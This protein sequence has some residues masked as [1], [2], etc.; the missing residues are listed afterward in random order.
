MSYDGGIIAHA[1]KVRKR[2]K[3]LFQTFTI[4]VAR[5]IRFGSDLTG[6]PG[7]PV[8]TGTLRDS[9]IERY[10]SEWMWRI[11]TSIDYAAYIEDDVGGHNYRVGGP[12]SVKLTVLGA[13]RILARAKEVANRAA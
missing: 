11:S 4:E 8:D 2:H 9:W 6:A 7:Q 13:E 10:L 3:V 1:I 12:H 5:S